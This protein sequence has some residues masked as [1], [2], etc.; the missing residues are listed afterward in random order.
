[1]VS[2]TIT[3]FWHQEPISILLITRP[4][5]PRS[6]RT[7]TLMTRRVRKA[8]GSPGSPPGLRTFQ[9]CARVDKLD[10]L[11]LVGDKLDKNWMFHD[12]SFWSRPPSDPQH[13]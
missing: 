2:S 12:S 13:D 6:P 1:M 3:A 8:T 10:K 5:S 7:S 9:P 4:R 11:K